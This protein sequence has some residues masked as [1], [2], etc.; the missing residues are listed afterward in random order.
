MRILENG[1][2]LFQ[3]TSSRLDKRE[4]DDKY[5]EEVDNKVEEVETP[6]RVGDTDRRCICVT[7]K[8]AIRRSLRA[9]A[10]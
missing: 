5:A 4:I 1:V 7:S 9:I 8:P 2:K 10:A 6:G 3:T